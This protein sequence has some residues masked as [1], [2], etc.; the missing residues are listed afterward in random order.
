MVERGHPE[1]IVLTRE[2][3]HELVWSEPMRK[4]AQRFQISD[5]GLKKVC[6]RHRI[7]VPARG[8]WQRVQ[9]GKASP[10]IPLPVLKDAQPIRFALNAPAPETSADLGP[11]PALEAEQAFAPVVVS[12]ALERPHPIAR[13]MRQ[14]LKGRKP[15]D[16]GAIR[17]S[18][19]DVLSVRIHP[20]TTDR[21]LRIADALLRAFEVRRFELRPGKRGARFGGSLQV[22]VDDETFTVSIEERMRRETH[23]PTEEEL[24]RR[25]RGLYVYSRSYDYVSTDELTLKIEPSHGTG[26]QSSWRDTR[27]SA[28]ERRLGEVMVSLRQHAAWRKAERD[29]AKLRE[30]RLQ[31]ELQRRAELRTRVEAERRAIERLEEQAANWRRAEQIRAY[32]AAAERCAGA[33]STREQA[34]WAEWARAYA[35]RLDPLRPSPHS[36]LDTPES[37]FQPIALWRV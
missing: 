23:K 26:L 35:D 7:P 30:E 31:L 14:E 12:E 6:T 10:Q 11:D 1:T 4:L 34:E 36:V 5:V 25:R 21:V 22:V 16:Y 33:S 19:P 3:L 17:C 27:Y 2:E 8:H 15:D 32:A 24:S 18:G 29:K 9:A 20:A 37:E 13:R 28:V